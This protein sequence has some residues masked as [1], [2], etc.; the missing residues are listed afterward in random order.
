[1]E[2]RLLLTIQDRLFKYK[3]LKYARCT[4]VHNP[5]GVNIPGWVFIGLSPGKIAIPRP[6]FFPRFL[7]FFKRPRFPRFSRVF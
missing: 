5:V 1:M 6:R 2:T 4:G 3:T 7:R